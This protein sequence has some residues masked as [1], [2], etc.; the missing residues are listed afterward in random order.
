MA[1]ALTGAMT[2]GLLALVRKISPR[3]A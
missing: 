1:A 2:L 3:P